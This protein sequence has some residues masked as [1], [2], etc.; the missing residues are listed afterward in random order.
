MRALLGFVSVMANVVNPIAGLRFDIEGRA[1][2]PKEALTQAELAG[3]IEAAASE[4]PDIRVMIIVGIVSG[5]RF[6]ELSALEWKDFDLAEG[7]VRIQRSQVLGEVGPPKTESSRRR[8]YLPAEVVSE[9]QR[10]RAWQIA[11][12]VAG[13]DKGLVFPSTK[14]G[15]RAP[16]VLKKPL[17]RCCERAGIDKH[18][19]S[20]C[21]RVTTNNLVRQ[22]A[23]DAAARAMVG[24]ATPAMTVLY[25]DVDKAE[26]LAVGRKAFG[27]WLGAESGVAGG[28]G[29]TGPT[30]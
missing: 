11:E 20:H 28:T 19:T 24:H 29:G 7:S 22:A 18:L 5:M 21:L 15:Y 25:S 4:S 26:R 16:S 2:T 12:Q 10:H 27:R 8:V 17:A 14:G 6:C 23:G 9:L 1:R 13:L 30:R 3:L